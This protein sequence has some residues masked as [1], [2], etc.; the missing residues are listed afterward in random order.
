MQS[1]NQHTDDFCLQLLKTGNSQE[2]QNWLKQRGNYLGEDLTHEQSIKFA[3][4]LYSMGAHKVFAVDIEEVDENI[5]NTGRLIVELPS[6]QF[7]RIKIF[8][9]IGDIQKKQGFDADTD[10]GQKYLFFMID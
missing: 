9:F 10:N 8:Q 7:D 4:N 5:E 6:S 3:N 1:I 2:L